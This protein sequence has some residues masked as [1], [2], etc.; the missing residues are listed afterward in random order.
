MAPASWQPLTSS[1]PRPLC[2]RFLSSFSLHDP[3]YTVA[4]PYGRLPA[5]VLS[6]LDTLQ[7]KQ[8]QLL[9]AFG[10]GRP[11]GLGALAACQHSAYTV[12][13]A[14]QPSA[15]AVPTYTVS[16]PWPLCPRCPLPYCLHGPR[17]PASINYGQPHS[18]YALASSQ[19]SPFPAPAARQFS[20]TANPTVFVPSMLVSLQLT[21]PQL[22]GIF[23]L[24][25]TS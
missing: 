14:R 17:C 3:S 6:L 18:P 5:F 9:G 22:L 10:Y 19:I 11:H 2:P 16:F 24:R 23:R 8:L 12:S 1:T 15:T 21:R 4:F 13:D 25:P 7:P 20:A